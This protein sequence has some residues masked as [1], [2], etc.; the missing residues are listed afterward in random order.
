VVLLTVWPSREHAERVE[1]TPAS[2]PGPRPAQWATP[3]ERPG[4]PNLHM[5]S[6][7]LYRG[8][9]PTAEGFREL[10]AMGVR[11]VL[12]LRSGHS[13]LEMVRGGTEKGSDP[14]SSGL[15][16]A[17]IP[18]H[19]WHPEKEDI[20]AF[21]QVVTDPAR[22]PVFVHCEYGADRTGTACAA[23]RVAVQGW[24]VDQA[25]DEMVNGGFGFHAIWRERLSGY[26]RKLD[27]EEIKRKAGI[28]GKPMQ[29]PPGP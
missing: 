3:V 27:F 16:Y 7:G 19:A 8:A 18:M 13:D 21:L 26:L 20:V 17:S 29:A 6:S 11:T 4:L 22:A 10:K 1:Q 25:V 15:G 28:G 24:S 9:Q 23:Y 12:N 14:F 2:S 5:V